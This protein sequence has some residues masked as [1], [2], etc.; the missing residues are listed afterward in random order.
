LRG[1][2]AKLRGFAIHIIEMFLSRGTPWPLE[3]MIP[4]LNC[5]S[6]WLVPPPSGTAAACS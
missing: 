2:I 6:A 1:G 4:R 5:A 3:Y